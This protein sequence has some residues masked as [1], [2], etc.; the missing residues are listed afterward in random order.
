MAYSESDHSQS[1][2]AGSKVRSQSDSDLLNPTSAGN[3]LYTPGSTTM[4][5]M[6]VGGKRKNFLYRLVRPWKWRAKRKTSKIKSQG[7]LVCVQLTS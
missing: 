6:N 2:F 3:G 4:D 7:K 1:A 5:D